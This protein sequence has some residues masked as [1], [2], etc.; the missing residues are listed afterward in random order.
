MKYLKL[1]ISQTSSE[2]SLNNIPSAPFFT[3]QNCAKILSEVFEVPLQAITSDFLSSIFIQ[4]DDENNIAITSNRH[5]SLFDFSKSKESAFLNENLLD[6][7]DLNCSEGETFFTTNQVHNLKIAINGQTIPSIATF[8]PV[9]VVQKDGLITKS[10][11]KYNSKPIFTS[12]YSTIP[13]YF[14]DFLIFN[15]SVSSSFF[16]NLTPSFFREGEFSILDLNYSSFVY[17]SYNAYYYSTGSF[18]S[19]NSIYRARNLRNSIRPFS[20]LSVAFYSKDF[21]ANRSEEVFENSE[22]YFSSRRKV[23]KSNNIT[24]AS[25]QTGFELKSIAPKSLKSA[26]GIIHPTLQKVFYLDTSTES[27]SEAYF[28]VFLP[29]YSC[30]M[31]TNSA[32]TVLT[33]EFFSK[34]PFDTVLSVFDPVK[35][36]EII[37]N[38]LSSMNLSSSLIYSKLNLSAREEFIRK[39]ASIKQPGS[40]SKEFLAKLNLKLN[41]DDSRYKRLSTKIEDTASSLKQSFL[42][43]SKSVSLTISFATRQFRDLYQQASTYFQYQNETINVPNFSSSRI[44]LLLSR[45]KEEY[46]KLQ[47]KLSQALENKDYIS[48]SFYLNYASLNIL[49]ITYTD[50]HNK[51]YTF[52]QDDFSSLVFQDFVNKQLSN[53]KFSITELVAAT[54]EPSKIIVD[55]NLNKPAVIGGPYIVRCVQSFNSSNLNMTIKLSSRSSFFGIINS[56]TYKCHPHSKPTNLERLYDYNSCC[57]GEATPL[58]SKAMMAA[59]LKTLMLSINIWLNSANSSDYW[60]RDYVHFI[61]YFEY[62]QELEQMKLVQV[63]ASE[64]QET[65]EI[66]ETE[67]YTIEDVQETFSTFDELELTLEDFAPPEQDLP[68]VQPFAE[69]TTYTRYTSQENQEQNV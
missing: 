34:T 7:Q 8:I 54:P 67:P 38:M 59:D 25:K 1:Y 24:S 29:N 36:Q 53:N 30:K 64:P 44:A 40:F 43:K 37:S 48:D 45:Q 66:Q 56:N 6:F 52:N 32:S 13:E 16:R 33:L 39:T 49:K 19:Y 46:I 60:G 23:L 11:K 69:P 35:Y 10:E 65:Q 28:F 21:I 14:E 62:E 41:V 31:S 61:K 51:N 68:P 5:S 2:A 42:T 63:E 55:G 9:V 58:I 12:L 50:S 57:L 20:S 3:S 17:N 4:L 27:F 26:T 47:E 18:Q 15:D 22:D